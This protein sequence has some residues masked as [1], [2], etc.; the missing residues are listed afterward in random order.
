MEKKYMQFVHTDKL[1]SAVSSLQME[2]NNS[3]ND[4]RFQEQHHFDILNKNKPD[5]EFTLN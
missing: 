1:D 4:L 5:K 2:F 3:L